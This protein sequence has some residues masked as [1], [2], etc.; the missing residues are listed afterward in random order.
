MNVALKREIEGWVRDE[1][2]HYAKEHEIIPVAWTILVESK[3]DFVQQRTMRPLDKM[4]EICL[5]IHLRKEGKEADKLLFLA[6]F[7]EEEQPMIKEVIKLL[8]TVLQSEIVKT[9]E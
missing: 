3:E 2:T 6:P 4:S 7:W 9:Y 5:H 8:F 1:L